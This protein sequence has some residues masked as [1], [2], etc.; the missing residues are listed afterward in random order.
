MPAASHLTRPGHRRATEISAPI[1]GRAPSGNPS[2]AGTARRSCSGP[3]TPRFPSPTGHA[4]TA[5][6]KRPQPADDHLQRAANTPLAGADRHSQEKMT[7]PPISGAD[8]HVDREHSSFLDRDSHPFARPPR[9]AA[10]GKTPRKNSDYLWNR[11]DAPNR[12]PAT[13]PQ[14]GGSA[15][16]CDSSR[17]CGEKHAPAPT[18]HQDG[19][20]HP[21]PA[22]RP[23]RA[24]LGIGTPRLCTHVAAEAG[25]TGPD[26][27]GQASLRVRAP[28]DARRDPRQPYPCPR[29]SGRAGTASAVAHRRPTA[30]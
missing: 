19:R 3:R 14:S 15:Q 7:L 24:A 12:R 4:G 5:S 27:P 13:R 18:R 23:R 29:G 6:V 25:A 10:T 16:P 11:I 2:L 30:G 1:S 8:D 9:W 21:I 28:A 22:L 17:A 26:P 20:H